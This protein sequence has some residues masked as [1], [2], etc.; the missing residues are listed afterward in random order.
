[1][2]YSKFAELEAYPNSPLELSWKASQPDGLCV[3]C[4]RPQSFQQSILQHQLLWTL[5]L[6]LLLLAQS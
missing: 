1:M 4:Q 3:H 6:H 5:L 2:K